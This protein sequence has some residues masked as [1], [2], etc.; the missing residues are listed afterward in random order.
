MV[1]SSGIE[2]EDSSFMLFA[3]IIPEYEGWVYPLRT[4]QLKNTM[5]M[6][7]E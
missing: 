4:S 7:L 5:F 3:P 6:H 2:P 1:S